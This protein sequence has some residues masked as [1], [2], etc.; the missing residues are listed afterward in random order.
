M[1]SR[2]RLG[3]SSTLL[4][5][6]LAACSSPSMMS[7]N[8]RAWRP[9]LPTPPAELAKPER[10]A[11][12]APAPTGELVTVDKGELLQLSQGFKDAI[13]MVATLNGR[14]AGWST[15]AACQRRY[16]ATGVKGPGC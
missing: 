13:G 16:I 3:L 14:I 10:P 2:S 4:L 15:W 6:I 5:S 8:A 9:T 11:K 1:N 7:P 12:L